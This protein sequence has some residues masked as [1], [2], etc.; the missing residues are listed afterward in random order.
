LVFTSGTVTAPKAVI[1][2][3]GRMVDTGKNIGATIYEI[4]PNDV[5]YVAMPL[6]HAN[7]LMCG[8]MPALYYGVALG[9]IRKF[10]KRRWLSDIRR[11][12]AT[13]FNYTGK[14]L[15]YILS[16]SPEP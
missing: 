7:A 5:G 14:P 1:C 9:M 8:Y 2:S 15:A 13:F 4:T 6:F 12:G 3:H 11:Y 10:S 16:A